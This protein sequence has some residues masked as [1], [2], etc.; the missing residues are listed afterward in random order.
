MWVLLRIS[1]VVM[2]NKVLRVLDVGGARSQ[3]VETGLE[4]RPWDSV[5]ML[6]YV[7][8]RDLVHFDSFTCF[9]DLLKV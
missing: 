3:V 5:H 2:H 4:P 1:E 9:R 7:M 6:D 8:R